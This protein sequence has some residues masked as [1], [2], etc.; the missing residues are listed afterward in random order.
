MLRFKA[1]VVL[2]LMVSRTK[3]ACNDFFEHIKRQFLSA[4]VIKPA[5][6]MQALEDN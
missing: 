3:N 4:N 1:E 6:M 2:F 5:D